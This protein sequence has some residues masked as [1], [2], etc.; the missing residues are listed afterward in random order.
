[1]NKQ[2]SNILYERLSRDDELAGPSNSIK[3]QQSML[4]EYAER[5]G[6]TPFIHLS[7]DG[8]SGTNYE[9]PGWQELIAMVER[10]EVSTIVLKDSSRM[11]RNYLQSGL[12]R[13]MFRERGVR[14]IM[15]NDGFDSNNG[16]GDDFTPFREIMSEWYARDTS[17]KIKSVIAAKGKSG[18]PIT[19]TPPYGFMKD[20][21]E[22]HR[23]LIDPEAAAVVKR[24]FQMTV[25]GMG[26]Y[27][28]AGVLAT[29]KIER[30]SYYL[31]S[32]GR[33]RHKNDYDRSQPY[34][35]GNAT[36][37]RI[38]EKPEYA[39]HTV[40][41]RTSSQNFKSKKRK[42]NAQEDW[43]IFENTHET[44]VNQETFDLVQK[45]RETPRRIDTLGE[46]NPLT[47][48]LF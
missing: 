4:E 38:L 26:I 36:I 13:E 47:C 23:W 17:K 31:G 25:D 40:N 19:G 16:E 12:Y 45:L 1:M 33:G 48:L 10:D 24:I 28:I 21:E 18:K 6:L 37:A 39:G 5:N 8:Y 11:G 9:R 27:T 22:K 2:K 7:D 15:V 3:N 32:R 30:P 43:L 41:F 20:P 35:W 14:L 34:A 29:E 44:I 42:K 46:A